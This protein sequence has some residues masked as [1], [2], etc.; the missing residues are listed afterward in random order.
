MVARVGRHELELDALTDKLTASG[1]EVDTAEPVCGDFRGVIVAE[2][3]ECESHPNA[4]KL[5][6]CQVRTNEEA[7]D[8]LNIVCGAPN[9]RPGIRVP[10]AVVGASLGPDFTVGKATLRGVDSMGMLCSAKE[11]GLADD[12]SGL[13]ELPAD[14]PLGENLRDFL[15]LDDA[16]VSLELTPNRPDCLSIRGLARD[17]SASFD[18]KFK[19]IEINSVPAEIEDKISVT[20]QDSQDCPRFAG[21]IIRGIDVNAQT[22]L[23]MVERLRRCGVRSIGPVVDIT[24]YVMLE[25]GQPMHAFDLDK[26]DREIIV[27]RGLAGE[28]LTL[29]DDREIDLD[30]DALA[31]CDASGPIALAGIM[32]GLDSSVTSETQNILFESAFFSPPT[33]MGKARDYGM[34]TDASHRFERGVDPAGQENGLERATALLVE[35]TGG[36]PGPVIVAEE[37]RRIPANQA[38]VLRIDRLNKV[39]GSDIDQQTAVGILRRLGMTVTAESEGEVTVVAPPARF[40]IAIEEDL[41]EE[42]VRIYGYERL[43]ETAPA[44]E[45]S[46]SAQA[47]GVVSLDLVR[48]SLISNGYQEVI[49]YSFVEPSLLAAVHQDQ[50][51]LSLSNPLSAEMSVMRTSLHPGLLTTLDR[52]IRSQDSRVR[53]FETVR[54]YL[55]GETLTESHRVA[56]VASGGCHPESWSVASRDIDF[57]DIKGEIE[58]LIAFRGLMSQ[59][60]VFEAVDLPWIHPGVGAELRIGNQVF[61][62]CGAV[63]PSVLKSLKIRETVYFFEIE[64]GTLLQ[65]E[66]PFAKEYSR[67]PS[68]RRDLAVMVPEA[69]TYDQLKDCITASAGQ[70]LVNLVLFDVYQGENLKKGYKSLAIGLILQDVSS[71][72]DDEDVD[73]LIQ[74]VIE[75]LEQRLGAHLRG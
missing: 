18:A 7:D 53:L 9:A 12:H 58:Q 41:I 32:G 17:V 20:L 10:L 13:L 46:A 71:T 65:R 27:R 42:V 28:K 57:F 51:V 52:N 1:L 50:Q 23:W 26:I 37:P 75:S 59:P 31:I 60:I 36:Q 54:A 55:Q 66:L 4:D 19:P 24:N 38:V 56:A 15:S 69:T 21:R 8:F 72:L 11:L 74:R 48:Q 14:A 3:V 67:L 16:T 45:V 2:I 61:G 25:L 34:H 40:D 5:A 22:P 44:G 62:W 63:H 30:A 68:V 43:P 49:N 47:E 73:Q 70:L 29:L 33:I 64:L 35:I 6:V 39:L